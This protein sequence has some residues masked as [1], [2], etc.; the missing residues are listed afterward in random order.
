MKFS[1]GLNKIFSP[2]SLGNWMGVDF[3]LHWSWWMMLVFLLVIGPFT[4]SVFVGLFFIIALHELGHVWAAKR[5]DVDVESVMLYITGGIA[6]THGITAK[7][8]LFITIA[9]PLVNLILIPLFSLL[10]SATPP[11]S[12]IHFYLEKLEFLN[13][14]ILF[15]NLVPAFPLDG[16]RILRAVLSSKFGFYRATLWAT[17]LSSILS[18]LIGLYALMIGKLILVVIA[19]FIYYAAQQEL[20][21]L[22]G[23]QRLQAQD[24]LRESQR[25]IAKLKTQLDRLK[26]DEN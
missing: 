26:G 24:S 20:Q 22:Q 6:R 16:G 8:E 21:N 25:T 3:Y 5:S 11:N 23:L 17:T 14:V 19:L 13:L 10:V 12:L 15:F 18:V 4:A 7:N 1:E 9:G 2:V